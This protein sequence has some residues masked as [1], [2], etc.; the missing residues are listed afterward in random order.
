[1]QI[2][3]QAIVFTGDMTTPTTQEK[4]LI[5]FFVDNGSLC[6]IGFV[7]TFI[8]GVIW[9]LLGYKFPESIDHL[10]KWKIY[11]WGALIT[12]LYFILTETIWGKTIGKF[13]TKTKVVMLDG[14]KPKFW[15]IVLRTIA[16]LI[17][18]ETFSFLFSRP[19]RGWHDIISGTIVADENIVWSQN[20]T[21][22]NPKRYRWMLLTVCALWLLT[23]GILNL[24]SGASPSS[25]FYAIDDVVVRL[26]GGVSILFS[27]GLFLRRKWAFVGSLCCLALEVLEVVLT[28]N[29]KVFST[30]HNIGIL[31]GVVIFYGVPVALLVRLRMASMR[32]K[33]EP[34]NPQDI[35]KKFNFFR[36]RFFHLRLIILFILLIYFLASSSFRVLFNLVNIA[37]DAIYMAGIPT[38]TFARDYRKI[39]VIELEQKILMGFDKDKNKILGHGERD[40]FTHDTGLLLYERGQTFHIKATEQEIVALAD[41]QGYE[42]RS[43]KQITKECFEKARNEQK[44]LYSLT[45]NELNKAQ[46]HLLTYKEIENWKRGLTKFG[47]NIAELVTVFHKYPNGFRWAWNEA[48]FGS[49][50]LYRD[51]FSEW[52]SA[53]KELKRGVVIKKIKGEPGYYVR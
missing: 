16:R 43:Y 53:F 3:S 41:K 17:P 24:I 9:T 27:L 13:I 33:T 35:W 29:L 7:I 5:N 8:I 30:S 31:V 23:I 19:T 32:S 25:R 1:M 47:D 26:L 42:K 37:I 40:K 20:I 34:T 12:A 10:G 15:N 39:E 6:V 49:L 51:T 48:I 11:L 14:S 46:I 21:K 2:R 22:Q 50:H 45:M 18:F 38:V 52:T 4:R 28:W 44:Q 36:K